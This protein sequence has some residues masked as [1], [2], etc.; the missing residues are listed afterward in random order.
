MST[1]TLVT[2]SAVAL[3]LIGL[4][5]LAASRRHRHTR[6]M[7]FRESRRMRPKEGTVGTAEDYACTT[8]LQTLVDGM[9][10]KWCRARG[11]SAALGSSLAHRQARVKQAEKNLERSQARL[12]SADEAAEGQRPPA[13]W[14]RFFL[15]ALYIGDLT[16]IT[17]AIQAESGT[18]TSGIALLAALSLGTALFIFGKMGGHLAK[19]Q[20]DETRGLVVSRILLGL[21]AVLVIFGISLMLLRVGSIWAWLVLSIAPALGSAAVTILGP[22][23]EQREVARRSRQLP[24]FQKRVVQAQR[25]VDR[26]NQS[27]SRIDAESEARMRRYAV[28]AESEIKRPG[29]PPSAGSHY[30]TGALQDCENWVAAIHR[31]PVTANSEQPTETDPVKGETDGPV[32]TDPIIAETDEPILDGDYLRE[33]TGSVNGSEAVGAT[34]KSY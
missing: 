34:G 4:A 3:A 6:P 30:V 17:M 28:L 9:S 26:V 15:V 13:F 32:D 21:A 33:E 8:A 24:R 10:L 11:R 25:A 12:E 5:L 2:A 27:K 18:S 29:V 19:D 31:N 7:G 22:T 14:G 23:A 1:T 20:I 16:V